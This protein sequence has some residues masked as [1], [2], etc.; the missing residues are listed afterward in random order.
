MGRQCKQRRL[1]G[2]GQ[3][4]VR[5]MKIVLLGKNGQVGHEL[6]RALLPFGDVIALDRREAHLESADG[7]KQVLKAHAPE[8][9]VNAAAYTAVDKAESDQ[10]T[11]FTV[12]ALA[13]GLLADYA[14]ENDALLVHYSTDYVFDGEKAD[15]YLEADTTNPQSAY[16]R[17]KCAGEVA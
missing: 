10:D 12:N 4:A 1:P 11:A 15:P 6:Q 14:R 8:I 13:V 16:G 3:Q 9:I 17:S 2:L 5:C 7:L